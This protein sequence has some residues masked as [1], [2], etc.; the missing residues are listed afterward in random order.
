MLCMFKH[1]LWKDIIH[2]SVLILYLKKGYKQRNYAY[3]L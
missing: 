2:N 1:V 3:T